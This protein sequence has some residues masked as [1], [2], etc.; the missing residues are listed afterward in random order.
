MRLPAA[1]VL[2]ALLL[3]GCGAQTA[4]LPLSA[5]RSENPSRTPAPSVGVAIP[6]CGAPEARPD[7]WTP[8][9]GDAGYQLEDLAYDVWTPTRAV[10]HGTTRITHGDKTGSTYRISVTFDRPQE[11]AEFQNRSLFSRAVVSYL[12]GPGPEG[13]ATDT[14]DLSEVW[15]ESV[16]FR[17]P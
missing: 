12:D 9:C 13:S 16:E 17:Q 5:P 10:A 1:P 14:F 15:E 8:S 3:A 7:W 2:T 11:V 4:T 6:T